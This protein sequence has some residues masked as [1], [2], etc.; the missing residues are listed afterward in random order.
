MATVSGNCGRDHESGTPIHQEQRHENDDDHRLHEG[1]NKMLQPVLDRRRLIR[2]RLDFHSLRQALPQFF[3]RLL[4][5]VVEVANDVAD[6]HLHRHHHRPLLAQGAIGFLAFEDIDF[7]R[8]RRFVHPPH[9]EE[10]AQI[11]RRARLC[12]CRRRFRAVLLRAEIRRTVGP[13]NSALRSATCPR[14]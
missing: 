8:D 10:V 12:R 14:G 5:G 2:E 7:V 6:A 11:D 4:H 1:P 3:G 13:E 9:F